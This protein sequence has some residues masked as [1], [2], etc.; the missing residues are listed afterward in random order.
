MCRCRTSASQEQK[1]FRYPRSPRISPQ[2]SAGAF[3]EQSGDPTQASPRSERRYSAIA[4]HLNIEF[5]RWC[6]S[7]CALARN[8]IS[9]GL[10]KVHRAYPQPLLLR[11]KGLAYCGNGQLRS[12]PSL[13][14]S[15]VGNTGHYRT[16]S[17]PNLKSPHPTENKTWTMWV[18][19][20]TW[21][22]ARPWI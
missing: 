18:N 16:T 10:W 3:M 20:M 2:G 12:R 19:M 1:C 7:A 13:L 8:P 11:G 4:I 15:I 9:Q 5:R 21:R 22:L 6:S 14:I 17:G